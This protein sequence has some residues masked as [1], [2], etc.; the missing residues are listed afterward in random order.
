MVDYNTN[1]S[2]KILFIFPTYIVRFQNIFGAKKCMS[3]CI[4]NCKY[5]KKM[6]EMIFIFY[7]ICNIY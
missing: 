7:E 1:N 4:K 6:I 3:L 5:N 2:I